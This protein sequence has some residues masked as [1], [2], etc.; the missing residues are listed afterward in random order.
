M[1]EIKITKGMLE[2]VEIAAKQR[3]DKGI[4]CPDCKRPYHEPMTCGEVKDYLFNEE[5]HLAL[6]AEVRRL[7]E[8]LRKEKDFGRQ[9]AAGQCILDM[10][11][12]LVGD[13]WGHPY[14]KQE[15]RVKELESTCDQN[16]AA[17]DVLHGEY[18]EL[19][20]KLERVREWGD[21]L[22]H[23]S[24]GVLCAILDTEE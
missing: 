5:I 22:D 7:W 3:L 9:M 21:D 16:A 20:A 12:G 24:Y 10:G 6:C 14:C 18:Q 1:T 13:D 2:E 11:N 19:K 17:F 23:E 8:D 4:H 15:A